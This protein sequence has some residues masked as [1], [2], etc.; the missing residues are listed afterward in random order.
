MGRLTQDILGGDPT[1][2]AYRQEYEHLFLSY[3]T[4]VCHIHN[5][6][7]NLPNIFIVFLKS[8]EM[9][10]LYK[11]MMSIES[12]YDACK[13]FLEYDPALYKS[14]YIRNFLSANDIETL[15]T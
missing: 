3:C 15:M 13:K 8:K 6:K 9:R 7:M 2:Q 1:Y 10:E 14:K 12:D 5:K 11:T 4:L